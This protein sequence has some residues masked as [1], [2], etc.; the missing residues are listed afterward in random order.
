MTPTEPKRPETLDPE[1]IR[2]LDERMASADQ[3]EKASVRLR[4]ALKEDRA[5]LKPFAPA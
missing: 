2:I 5:A 1:A 4:Q 3:D